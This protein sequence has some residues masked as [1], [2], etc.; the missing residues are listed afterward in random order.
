MNDVE[1]ILTELKSIS[2]PAY[3]EKMAHFGIDTAKAFGIRVPDIRSLAKQ[4]GKNQALS[5][6][7]WKTEIHEARLLATF[8]G[9]YKQVDEAQINAWTKDFNSW[10][11]CDQAC[12][13]LFV[14][15]P[16]FM[17]KVLEF[18]QAEAVF[19]KR[20]GF[21]LMAVAAVHL[22]KEPNETFLSFLSIIEREAY[23]NRNFVK[24]AINWALRQ[25]GKRNAFLHPYAIQTAHNILSQNNKKANWIALDALRELEGQKVSEKLKL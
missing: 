8:I 3:L 7:L 23:D 21:V 1:F 25:I 10:D 22:K 15:T 19:V 18:S 6:E 11:I 24:K 20:T 2:E 13:N 5:L 16:Y 17:P 12:A 14:K 9:D 4:V